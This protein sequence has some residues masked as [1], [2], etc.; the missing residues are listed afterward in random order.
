MPDETA[1]TGFESRDDAHSWIL[2][3]LNHSRRSADRE[4]TKEKDLEK[5]RQLLGA[6]ILDVKG[7]H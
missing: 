4:K 6:A 1:V 3:Y 7:E 2:Q 5:N